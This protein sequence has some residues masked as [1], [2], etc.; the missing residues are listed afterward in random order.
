MVHATLGNGIE[1][2]DPRRVTTDECSGQLCWAACGD[3]CIG[4]D[5]GCNEASAS[6]G[7]DYRAF[8]F[9]GRRLHL[10]E[11]AFEL[12]RLLR[13]IV[14]VPPVTGRDP[15]RTPH[16]RD[17]PQSSW[18]ATSIRVGPQLAWYCRSVKRGPKIRLP[19]T[20]K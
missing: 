6:F 14:L 11:P 18:W 4:F 19:L 8:G 17:R 9:F 20:R 12:W 5:G 13:P 16:Q 3:A 15:G 1:V 10:T 7:L 2:V